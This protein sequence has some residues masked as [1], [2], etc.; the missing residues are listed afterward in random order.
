MDE[1]RGMER[2]MGNDYYS[3]MDS[4]RRQE[5]KDGG[6]IRE[7]HMA[8]ANL[9]QGVMYQPYPK[10]DYFRYDLNDDIRG[11]DVQIDDDVRGERRKSGKTY[12]EKY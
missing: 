3:G 10:T 8:I 6:M 1:S 5:M 4:R 7:D 12:P 2:K 11:V 9:P